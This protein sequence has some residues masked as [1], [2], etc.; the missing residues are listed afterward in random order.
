MAKKSVQRVSF[1]NLAV[2]K[3]VHLNY[4]I[5]E[6][7]DAGLVLTGS[8]V[9]S[10][11]N[12]QANLKG[13]YCRFGKDR[14]LYVHET[15]IA[16]YKLAAL[17]KYN[18]VRPKKLLLTQKE[19]RKLQGGSSVP[20]FSVVPLKLYVKRRLVKIEIALVRGKKKYDKRETI[21]KREVNK[22][23]RQKVRI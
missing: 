1:N 21:K 14:A 9:K 8:E 15:Y 11:K 5:I 2:N 20:G 7:F 6:R 13:S 3:T 17:L 4:E 16:P 12:G 23:I 22:R 18:A 19:L 10:C